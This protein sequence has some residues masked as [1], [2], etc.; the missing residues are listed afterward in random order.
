VFD[1]VLLANELGYDQGE[2]LL[3]HDRF[4]SKLNEGQL[5]AYDQIV[6]SV[7]NNSGGMFFVYGYGGTGKTYLWNA[8]SF[9][10]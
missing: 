10:F 1:N 8:L 3:K 4:F 7:E 9:R 6:Q 5:Y 2:M